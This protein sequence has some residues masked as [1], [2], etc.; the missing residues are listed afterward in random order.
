MCIST[1]SILKVLHVSL[2]NDLPS[3]DIIRVGTLAMTAAKGQEVGIKL[4]VLLSIAWKISV[5]VLLEVIARALLGGW[6]SWW[7]EACSGVGVA[8]WG[9]DVVDPQGDIWVVGVKAL[10]G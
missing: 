6:W 5:G 3:W 4:A 1:R 2:L 8:T 9:W 10:P 7:N